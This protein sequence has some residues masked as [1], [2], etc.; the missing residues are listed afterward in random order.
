MVRHMRPMGAEV[1]RLLA[2]MPEKRSGD[3]M[4]MIRGGRTEIPWSRRIKIAKVLLH[5]ASWAFVGWIFVGPI[6]IGLGPIATAILLALTVRHERHGC[7]Y[8]SCGVCWWC[9]ITRDGPSLPG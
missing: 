8:N 7:V 3:L 9:G 1:I 4:P 5:L 6:G 2:E